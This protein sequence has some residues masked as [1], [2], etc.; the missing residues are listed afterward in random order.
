MTSESTI[1]AT[2]AAEFVDEI[3]ETLLAH[4][5]RRAAHGDAVDGERH[6]DPHEPAVM[7][8]VTLAL[9][10]RHRLPIDA[11][12]TLRAVRRARRD[13]ARAWAIG[14]AEYIAELAEQKREQD[15]E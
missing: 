9:V 11:D 14:C 12:R 4:R 2:S 1:P 6:D 15:P 8:D 13:S 5:A 10:I 7:L 3:E